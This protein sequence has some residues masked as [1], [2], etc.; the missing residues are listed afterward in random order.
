MLIKALRSCQHFA[1]GAS[2]VF[3][4]REVASI[5]DERVARILPYVT[6]RKIMI[7]GSTVKNSN[8]S[9]MNETSNKR[10]RDKR[11][12]LGVIYPN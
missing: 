10:N 11:K 5:R 4:S 8:I 6:E 3:Y 2:P 7:P 1:L 12:N 9:D